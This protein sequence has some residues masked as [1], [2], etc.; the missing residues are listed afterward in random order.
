[1]KF[2]PPGLVDTYDHVVDS[3]MRSYQRAETVENL[4]TTMEEAVKNLNGTHNDYGTIMIAVSPHVFPRTFAKIEAIKQREE[5]ERL[6]AIEAVRAAEEAER[7]AAEEA[8]RVAREAEEAERLAAE[9]AER[10]AREAE[11]A[12][13]V[14]REAASRISKSRFTRPSKPAKAS[15]LSPHAPAYVPASYS[16]AYAASHAPGC[17]ASHAPA[18]DYD[19]PLEMKTQQEKFL[20]QVCR[21]VRY[22]DG[23]PHEKAQFARYVG[24]NRELILHNLLLATRKKDK[25]MLD[26]LLPGVSLKRLVELFNEVIQEA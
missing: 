20:E 4:T 23:T 7:L 21:I 13:R 19:T 6:A 15:K 14:A 2:R 9:E 10:V 16:D 11:E 8:E 3:Y 26:I 12:E 5:A 1:M 25:R 17:A 22:S 18:Y 24:E